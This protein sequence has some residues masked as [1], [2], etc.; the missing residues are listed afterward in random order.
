MRKINKIDTN[1]SKHLYKS[2]LAITSDRY[3]K[4]TVDMKH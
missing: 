2:S 1:E 4:T 3:K